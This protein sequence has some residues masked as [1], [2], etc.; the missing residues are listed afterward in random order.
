MNRSLPALL[1][2][3][4][5]VVFVGTRPGAESL[6]TGAYY[7]NPTNSFYRSLHESG[8]TPRVLKP[9]EYRTL[10]EFGIGL[11]DAYDDGE[12]L[13]LRL[14][15]AAPI[16]VCFNSRG[17]LEASGAAITGEWKGPAAS[18]W[19]NITG[20]SIIWAVPDSSGLAG[21]FRADRLALLTQLR[22]RLGG[23]KPA[24]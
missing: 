4:L 1:G 3:G 17:A 16:A 24:A 18:S 15:R 6:R 12:A 19:V 20:V 9:S 10:L 7:A 23:A 21:R 22:Q 14:V 2:P 8:F 5:K 13:R 11:D